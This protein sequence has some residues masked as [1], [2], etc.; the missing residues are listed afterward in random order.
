MP[1]ISD[2]ILSNCRP[3]WLKVA[4]V[5]AFSH[6]DLGSSDDEATYETLAAELTV[7]VGAGRLE[8]IGD[9]SDWRNS[10]ARLTPSASLSS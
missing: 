2:A 1:S 4:R 10:E 7:L 3:T 5:V 9:L 8:A 6:R